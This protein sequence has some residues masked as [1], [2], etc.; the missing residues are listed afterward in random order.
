MGG[1]RVGMPRLL[2]AIETILC[3]LFPND[4][5]KLYYAFF[6]G[7]NY[8][9]LRGPIFFLRKWTV[10]FSLAHLTVYCIHSQ[11]L[12]LSYMLI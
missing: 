5:K 10:L 4:K 7:L 8:I 12:V 9:M 11:I 3:F 2:D 6:L 1:V